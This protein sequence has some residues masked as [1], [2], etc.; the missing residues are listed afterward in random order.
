M[1]FQGYKERTP[2]VPVS[3]KFHL[4][5]RVSAF[6]G[7]DHLH[8]LILM[9]MW[10]IASVLVIYLPVLNTLPVRIVLTLPLF[11]FIPGYCFIAALFPRAREIS[12]AERIAL[13][14]GFSVAL[15]SLMGL[16]LNFTPGG[17]RL[18]PVVLSI[19]LFTVLMIL[20]AWYRRDHLPGDERFM[21]SF[22]TLGRSINHG[23]LPQNESRTDR[24]L[25]GILVISV[26][27]A[28]LTAGFVIAFP[29][30]GERYSELFILG[31]NRTADDYPSFMVEGRG[32]PMYI[33]VGNHE[34]RN[35]TYSIERWMMREEFDTGKNLSSVKTMDLV[36]RQSFTLVH[37]ETRV[38]PV[39]LSAGKTEY[40]RVEFLLFN[41][42]VPGS[43]VAGSDRI[44]A[45]YR[46]VN[47]WITVLSP[48]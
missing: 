6:L 8:D 45:S 48:G 26:L 38:L 9:V 39:I 3:E 46:H 34:D 10:L 14:I 13:S 16:V 28:V 25:S 5:K 31:E 41:E 27:A 2:E 19:T 7:Q 36:D 40:N 42:T 29:Q 30:E 15:V 20:V 32:Y 37:N 1:A 35:I 33:G 23:L 11:L 22:L 44:N 18:D 4:S 47:L 43:E 24:I 12:V 21:V 17:I